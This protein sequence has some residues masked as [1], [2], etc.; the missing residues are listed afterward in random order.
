[1]LSILDIHYSYL[2]LQ[3][4]NVPMLYTG[5]FLDIVEVHHLVRASKS[6]QSIAPVSIRSNLWAPFDEI[7]DLLRNFTLHGIDNQT[8]D[9]R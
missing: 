1:M 6:P 2:F 9:G 5:P 3:F 4:G 7:V 8:P